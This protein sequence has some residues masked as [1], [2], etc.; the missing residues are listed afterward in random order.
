MP[1]FDFTEF[2]D[3]IKREIKEAENNS[4]SSDTDRRI[5]INRFQICPSCK[6]RYAVYDE[7]WLDEHGNEHISLVYPHY[8]PWCGNKIEDSP[9]RYID[10]IVGEDQ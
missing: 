4:N 10:I 1:D 8:C 2:Y 6:R 3:A 7:D 9:E 5:T